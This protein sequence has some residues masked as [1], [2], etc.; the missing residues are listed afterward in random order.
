MRFDVPPSS[1]RVQMNTAPEINARIRQ[2]TDASI[3]Y[4]SQNP[5][6]D[7]SSGWPSST[8]NGIS[9]VCARAACRIRGLRRDRTGGHPIAQWLIVPMLVTGFLW[10]YAVQG[11]SPQL[12]VLRRLGFRTPQ[13]IA[14]GAPASDGD[15]AAPRHQRNALGLHL[16]SSGPDG[17]EFGQVALRANAELQQPLHQIATDHAHAGS[18]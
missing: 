7:R 18:A 16:M 15:R 17:R 13:E 6:L 5:E 8:A 10:Q 1:T 2:E 14:E 4:Y 9:S 3:A 12:P 11:W